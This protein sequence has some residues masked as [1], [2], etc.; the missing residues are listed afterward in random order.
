[1]T[2]E[3]LEYS[4]RNSDAHSY[5]YVP[6]SIAVTMLPRTSLSLVGKVLNK[7]VP[8]QSGNEH[9]D[10]YRRFLDEKI[11]L[12]SPNTGFRTI[13]HA[14]ATYEQLKKTILSLS[15]VICGG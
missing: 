15:K 2:R 13:N 11:K 5:T 9:L 14:V 8:E 12:T 4:K 10:K 6:G 3:S 7:C 1:M